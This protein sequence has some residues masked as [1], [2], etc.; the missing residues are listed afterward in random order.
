MSIT[1]A[2]RY[3]GLVPKDFVIIANPKFIVEGKKLWTDLFPVAWKVAQFTGTANSD[4][5][6]KFVSARTIG[7]VRKNCGNRISVD[8]YMNV[9][10]SENNF[11]I[12][13]N[14]DVQG[15]EVDIN[16]KSSEHSVEVF[17]GHIESVKVFYG[18][19]YRSPLVLATIDK[20]NS[21][22]IME[23]MELAIAD[24]SGC[25]EYEMINF[26]SRGPWMIFDTK[27]VESQRISVE[28]V[29]GMFKS[30]DNSTTPFKQYPANVPL[31]SE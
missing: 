16:R 4:F 10:P 6:G 23:K 13:K 25:E 11:K 26:E 8:S 28:F 9:I 15:I 27:Q 19:K 14:G 22:M 7:T 30:I 21:L 12:F 3:N 18:D 5:V 17:N 20:E 1:I 24:I 29:N 31:F 2:I